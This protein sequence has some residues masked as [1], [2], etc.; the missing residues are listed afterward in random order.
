M[1]PGVGVFLFEKWT[2]RGFVLYIVSFTGRIL[3]D[4][5]LIP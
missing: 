5:S 4:I 3:G 1:L 2:R